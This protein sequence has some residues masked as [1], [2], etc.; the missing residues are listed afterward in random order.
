M[1]VFPIRVPPLRERRENIAQLAE[2]FVRLF[3]ER[4]GKVVP[5]IPSGLIDALK[6][7]DWPGN[8]REL[9]N[10]IER[11]VVTI[12]GGV[13]EVPQVGAEAPA[14]PRSSSTRTLA[15]VER[16][17][18]LST[19]QETNGVI[20]GWNGA[21][22]RLGLS[23]T[24]LIARMQRLGISKAGDKRRQGRVSAEQRVPGDIKHEAVAFSERDYVPHADL[25][26]T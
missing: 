18:I 12:R 13:L 20:G 2:H 8:V 3:A 11:A 24:T 15:Q 19:L 16:E 25:A 21:A 22:A 7:H 17:H 10:V 5:D 9:Q 4:Y 23:R 6:H 1:H 26:T 14:G